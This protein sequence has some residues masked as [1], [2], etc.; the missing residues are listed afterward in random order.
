MNFYIKPRRRSVMIAVV[1]LLA[2][3]AACS[4]NDA[5]L[6]ATDPDLIDPSALQNAAGAEGLRIGTVS[7][8]TTL[9]GASPANAEGV[10]FMGGLLADEWKSGDTFIQ[11]DETDKRTVDS[12]NTIVTAGYRYIHRTRIS[13]NLAIDALRKFAPDSAAASG[14]KNIAQMQWIR[15]YAELLSAENFCNGQ[16]FSDGSAGDVITE[17]SPLTVAQAFQR[18]ITSADSAITIIGTATDTASVRQLNAA[19]LVKARALMGLGGATNFA[20]ARTLVAGIPTG[21]AYNVFFSQNSTVNGIWNLNNNAGRYV[22]GDSVDAA[23]RI[24]NAIPFKS[25]KDPRVP[26]TSGGRA[27]DSATPFT[28]QDIWESA[29]SPPGSEDPIA[30]V[31]GIDARLIEAEVALFQGDVPTWLTIL[32]TLRQGPTQVAAGLTV[33][34]MTP[35]VAPATP[36]AQLSLQF[37]EK[38]FWTFGRGERLG[39][40]RRLVRQYGRTQDQVFPVGKFHK[41]GDYGTDVNLPVTQAETN[42]SLF[43]GCTDR[44]A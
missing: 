26:T 1:A 7:R 8:L 10:W 22:V 42:N 15:G 35:L 11:R 24:S 2:G 36:A 9:T 5:L 37:R 41:G 3:V 40:L 25:A 21:Y 32:N 16:P 31:N 4:V 44:A 17:G 28:Q 13:A 27:F 39:D 33:S 30:V 38:A 23:G 14:R 19:K 34:G 29:G 43:K 6:G 12:T 18:A 20:A